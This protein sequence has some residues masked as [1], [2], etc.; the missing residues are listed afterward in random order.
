[1]RISGNQTVAIIYVESIPLLENVLHQQVVEL[2][3]YDFPKGYISRYNSL[4][5]QEMNHSYFADTA[6][7]TL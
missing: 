1:M 4:G 6:S 7:D 5:A 3:V 2:I